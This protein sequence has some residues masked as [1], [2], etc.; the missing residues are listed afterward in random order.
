MQE[1]FDLAK[2]MIIA[3]R[4]KMIIVSNAFV[5]DVLLGETNVK[6]IFCFNT[7][8]KIIK[9]YGTPL[10]IEPLKDVPVFFTSML[11]G[12]GALDN[13]SFDR[14]VWHINYVRSQSRD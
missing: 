12:S 1:Q 3:A 2:D 11:S 8:E 5:R 7:D 6:S 9:K 13:G 10:I 4:P 14:L